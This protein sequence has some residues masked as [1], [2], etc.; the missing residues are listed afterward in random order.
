MD[1]GLM[2][3]FVAIKQGYKSISYDHPNL[4]NALKDTY[5]VIVYQEQVMQAARDLAGYSMAEADKLRKIM[6]KKQKDE[7]AEQKDKFVAGAML[8]NIEVG[9]DDGTTIT[10]HRASKFPCVDGVK[11]TVEE[12]ISAGVEI[13]SLT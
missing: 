2:D 8:G 6:G 7:M 1:S 3:D 9:L 12:A 4:E 13:V 11:R 5:G 10:V